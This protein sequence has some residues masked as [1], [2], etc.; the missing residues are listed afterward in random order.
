MQKSDDENEPQQRKL[1][2]EELIDHMKEENGF[3]KKQAKKR[4]KREVD[5]DKSFLCV[6]C[7]ENF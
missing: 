7:Q 4:Q 3:Q 2:I 5:P 1:T 6:Y